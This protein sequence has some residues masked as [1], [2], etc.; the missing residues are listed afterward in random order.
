MLRYFVILK[1]K[2]KKRHCM[3]RYCRA[4]AGAVLRLVLALL[5]LLGLERCCPRRSWRRRDRHLG[6]ALLRRE[7]AA[8]V[9]PQ[10]L[11]QDRLGAAGRR[12]V[13]HEHTARMQRLQQGRAVRMADG[14]RPQRQPPHGR[15]QHAQRRAQRCCMACA[16]V[17]AWPRKA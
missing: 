3:L 6:V 11:I 4:G 9:K 15:P 12:R 2:R 13:R 10:Q 8:A 1:W 7:R 14:V 16:G 5:L 17:P